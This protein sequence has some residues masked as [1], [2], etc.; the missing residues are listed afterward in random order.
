MS[1]SNPKKALFTFQNISRQLFYRWVRLTSRM[2]AAV[3]FGLRTE[4]Q[5]NLDVEGGGMLLS[6]HQ[7]MLDPVLVGLIANRKLNYLARKTLF[8][9][10]F[11]GF[12]IGMLDAIEIDRERGGLAGLREMLKRLQ[13]G[14]LVL[15]F[16]EGTRSS[17]GEIAPLKPGFIPVARRSQV[18]MMPI[19]IVGAYDCLPKGTKLPTRRP[20]AVV[21][22]ESIPASVYMPLSD[23]EII[24]M[25]S[26]KLK[27]LHDRGKELVREEKV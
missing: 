3:T 17:D 15:M 24:E 27:Q 2:I 18:P 11:F 13:Q 23:V 22:G 26:G 1:K 6:T 16:P 5:H 14:E 25:L 9:N 4:G 20:I 7:S 10:S 12:M 21:F 19:A 8:K